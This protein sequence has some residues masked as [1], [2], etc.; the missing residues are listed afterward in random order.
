M[1]LE[2]ECRE[3][4]VGAREQRVVAPSDAESTKSERLHARPRL[5]EIGG[6]RLDPFVLAERDEGVHARGE[7][8]GPPDE[9][10]L[11]RKLDE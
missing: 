4:L 10:A 9:R 3:Q 1:P 6:V 8:T 5:H 11:D 2:P 7:D